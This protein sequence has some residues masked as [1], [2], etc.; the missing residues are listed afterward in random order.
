MCL[1]QAK[2]RKWI[3][4]EK[5]PAE[6]RSRGPGG[7]HCLPSFTMAAISCP[8]A[9][10]ERQWAYNSATP[11]KPH[12]SSHSILSAPPELWL[13]PCLSRGTKR[14]DITLHEGRDSKAQWFW[15]PQSNCGYPDA[16]CTDHIS[17][18]NSQVELGN[19]SRKWL[20]PGH[21]DWGDKVN[22]PPSCAAATKDDMGN[23]QSCCL[24]FPV[25]RKLQSIAVS[26]QYL[27]RFS[28]KFKY[29]LITKSL[30]WTIHALPVRHDFLQ[31]SGRNVLH[32]R[33]ENVWTDIQQGDKLL[34]TNP[35]QHSFSCLLK[36]SYSKHCVQ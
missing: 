31:V 10:P 14:K 18:L 23:G 17:T 11:L 25:A 36:K 3:M 13:C 30:K 6:V 4:T 7:N 8:K 35:S 32:I 1:V 24:V 12:S 5:I 20:C 21:V 19:S 33:K 29:M 34:H 28:S 9:F 2:I 26:A 15:L 16:W 22:P 27:F